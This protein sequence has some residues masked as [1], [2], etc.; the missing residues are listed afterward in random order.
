MKSQNFDVLVVG[1]GSAGAIVGAR[2]ALKGLTV[3]VL[4]A[5]GKGDNPVFRIPLLTGVLHRQRYANWYYFTDPIPSLNGRS[6]FWPRGKALGGSS[7]INGMIYV[8]GLPHDYDLWAQ[9]G[10]KEWSWDQVK[11]YFERSVN[12]QGKHSEDIAV[13]VNRAPPSNPLFDVF[14]K[15]GEQAGWPATPDFNAQPFGVG[16]YHFTIKNGERWSTGRTFLSP[17]VR[18]ATLTVLTHAHVAR[19]NI[20][21]GRASSADVMVD[22]QRQRIFAREIVLSAGAINSPQLLLQSGIGPA[23]ELQALGIPVVQDLPGVGHNLQDHLLI[24]VQHSCKKPITLHNLVRIDRAALAVLQAHFLKSGVATSFPLEAGAYIKSRPGLELPDLQCTFL[25]GLSTGKLRLP[26][27]A[28]KP[29][30]AFFANC[31]M[32]RPESRGRITLRSNDPFAAPRIEPNYL[33]DP[34]DV[35]T[36]RDGVRRLREI[37]AQPAFDDFRGAELAPGPDVQT[38]AEIDAYIRQAADTV[39]HPVGTCKMGTDDQAVV[40]A[41]L[42]VRGIQGL[43]IA[44]ASIMPTIVSTNTHAASMMIGEKAADY[45]GRSFG[46]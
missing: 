8:R 35:V 46:V 39:Y 40:D 19:I 13:P 32:M 30:H 41:E 42:R 18:P 3:C 28:R 5:G 45:V 16:R 34:R 15:A 29:G 4:E 11:P 2:L 21:N 6:L 10:L 14:Q 38:D 25:P 7:A 31:Y 27:G 36:L 33:A 1:A 43:R 24:R 37:F 17:S 22:G 23:E 9:G 26:F 12:Y 44:D 20:D